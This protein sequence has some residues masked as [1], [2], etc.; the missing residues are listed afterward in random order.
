MEPST[1]ALWLNETFAGFDGW[2]LGA[3][4][5]VQQ[6]PAGAVLDPL[7]MLLHWFGTGGLGLIALGLVLLC[8]HRSRRSGFTVLLALTFGFL[9]T[10][11]LLKQLVLRPRPYVGGGAILHQWWLEAG[12]LVETVRSF[13]S[14]H[15]T[16][17]MAAMTALFWCGDKRYSWAAFLFA[18]IMGLS[19]CYL[20]V[21]YPTDVVGGLLSGFLAGT[22]AYF[23]VWSLQNCRN[24]KEQS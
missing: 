18:L 19:R 16:A 14:G 12:G 15:T 24:R 21:H 23:I 13:P 10:N 20:M 17:A 6:S 8:F 7:A 11:L 2:L 22:A 3:I 5:T 1:F 4:H 9:L